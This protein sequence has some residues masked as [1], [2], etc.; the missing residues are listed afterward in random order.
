MRRRPNQVHE[1][2]KIKNLCSIRCHPRSWPKLSPLLNRVLQYTI[3]HNQKSVM[4]NLKE[5]NHEICERACFLKRGENLKKKNRL[6]QFLLF[7]RT[8]ACGTLRLLTRNVKEPSAITEFPTEDFIKFY[9]HF[10]KSNPTVASLFDVFRSAIP[11]QR[12]YSHK[13]WP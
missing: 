7:W 9:R 6:P 12:G 11:L 13:V 5:Q 2:R 3:I 4:K 10:H 1:L 8:T